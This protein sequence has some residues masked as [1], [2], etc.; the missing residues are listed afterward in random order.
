MPKETPARQRFR[1]LIRQPEPQ[2]NLAEAALCIAWEDQGT[3]EPEAVLQQLDKIAADACKRLSR[4]TGPLETVNALNSYLFDE[5]Q[6]RGNTWS[7]NDPENSFLDHVLAT[8]SG[9]PIALAVIYLEVGWRLELP[10]AGLGLPGHFL[11]QYRAA[12]HNLFIDPFHGGRHWSYAD[13][14]N[15]VAAFYGS[16]TP[17]L[18][19]RLMEP[20]T[21]RAILARMLHNLKS[22]YIERQ[23]WKRALASVDRLLL[24][25]H[26]AT[27]E[28][29]DRGL[30]R[31]RVGQFHLAMEDF[32]RY[33]RRAPKAPDLANI[34]RHAR[35]IAAY[36]S[37]GN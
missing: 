8:R 27:T 25:D 18:M 19:D 14:E 24:I 12:G 26:G 17:T 33:A 37:R 1:A 10:V 35:T 32:D 13:C 9:L 3:G 11:V 15:Q 28:L 22:T 16:A 29:R 30:L 31:A 4:V 23:D 21:K 20:P 36:L 7:Y 6:F 5:L 34:Q 2:L